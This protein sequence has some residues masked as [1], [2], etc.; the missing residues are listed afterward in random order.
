MSLVGWRVEGNRDT[1]ICTMLRASA[2]SAP[3]TRRRSQRWIFHQFRGGCCAAAITYGAP[4]REVCGFRCYPSPSRSQE[5]GDARGL[6]FTQLS[7]EP[8]RPEHQDLVARDG[9]RG[10]VTVKEM[11]Q[12]TGPHMQETHKATH[13]GEQS[14]GTRTHP[15]ARVAAWTS[16]GRRL[17]GR[18]D[19]KRPK[20]EFPF[21]SN[22]LFSFSFPISYFR[23]PIEFTFE[24]AFEFSISNKMHN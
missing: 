11:H 6:E 12:T 7:R 2:K 8:L 9:E 24:S 16:V 3:T 18:G 5:V 13:G 14:L 21:F 15:S 19:E 17:L 23:I 10:V 4:P 20:R 22:F 1:Y